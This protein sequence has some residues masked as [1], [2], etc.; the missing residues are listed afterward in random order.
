MDENE[1]ECYEMLIL[2]RVAAPIMPKASDHTSHKQPVM[3]S[4]FE[5]N[6]GAHKWQRLCEAND[7]DDTFSVEPIGRSKSVAL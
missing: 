3:H 4:E 2:Q 1:D 5:R 7:T 6:S